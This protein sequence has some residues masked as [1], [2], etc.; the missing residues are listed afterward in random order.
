[1]TVKPEQIIP[2]GDMVLVRQK[3]REEKTA[4]G[5]LLPD[6]KIERDG[7]AEV[8]GE[9]VSYGPTAFYYGLPNDPD[10]FRDPN[11]PSVGDGVIFQKYAGGNFV[12]LDDNDFQYRLI[13]DTDVV[14]KVKD[15][16]NV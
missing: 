16:E 15:A 14:A 1:M 11:A 10:H 13:K 3:K 4:G 9:I 5:I 12:S 7:Y 6:E 2:Q 8:M